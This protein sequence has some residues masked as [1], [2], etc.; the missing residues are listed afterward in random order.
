MKR[1]VIFLLILSFVS[2][3]KQTSS[4]LKIA[5]A[6]NLQFAMEELTT[7]F[8]SQTGVE[9]LTTF[10]SSGKHT[11]QIMSGAEYDVF[12]SA[13]MKYAE[14]LHANKKTIDSPKIYAFGGLVLWTLKDRINPELDI[15][16]DSAIKH[17]AIPNPKTA[18]YG[19]AVEEVLSKHQ[20]LDSVKH[21]LVYGESIMQTNQFIYSG[22]AEIGFTAQSIVMSGKMDNVGTWTKIK[23]EDH[24]PIAQGM[25][26]LKN[27]R[28]KS[29]E[30]EKFKEFVFSKKGKEIL[31]KFG[32]TVAE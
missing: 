31:N 19:V 18:P 32:F 15:L 4:E 11:A 22:A 8:T 21:K 23:L 2:C 28:K 24:Q 27:G 29:A 17:I 9:C 1:V 30:A 14:Y 12:M 26:L 25:A 16:L 6:S 5:A 3:G 7:V 20:L 10:N 13:D